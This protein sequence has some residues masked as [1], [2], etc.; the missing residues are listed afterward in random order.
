MTEGAGVPGTQLSEV[1]LAWG[2]KWTKARTCTGFVMFVSC[3][4]HVAPVQCDCG[5]VGLANKLLK[6]ESDSFDIT[7]FNGTGQ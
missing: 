6:R 5:H 7:C 1:S 2:F 4:H 3:N